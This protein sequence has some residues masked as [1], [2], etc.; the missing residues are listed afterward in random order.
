[1]NEQEIYICELCQK[2]MPKSKAIDHLIYEH[3]EDLI[4]GYGFTNVKKL[5]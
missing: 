2:E 1:M 5:K 4:R 3:G